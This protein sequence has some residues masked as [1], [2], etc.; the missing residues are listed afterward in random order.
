MMKIHIPK[1][2]KTIGIVPTLNSNVT[3]IYDQLSKSFDVFILQPQNK[4]CPYKILKFDFYVFM[5]PTC[6]FHYL[7]NSVYIPPDT[8]NIHL[9]L[10]DTLPAEL[11]IFNPKLFTHSLYN[12]EHYNTFIK[13]QSKFLISRMSRIQKIKDKKVFG[14]YFTNKIYKEYAENLQ[15]YLTSKS[16]N[17][18]LIFLEDISYERLTCIDNIE[19]YVVLD[20]MSSFLFDC[21]EIVVVTLYEVWIAFY[22]DIWNGDYLPFNFQNIEEKVLSDVTDVVLMESRLKN[23]NIDN[24]MTA[25]SYETIGAVNEIVEGKKGIASVYENENIE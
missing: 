1:I 24:E 2:H 22:E 10:E 25:V 19:I 12:F 5:Q 23:I 18:Y 11:P 4:V 14:I 13:N 15:K 9:Y 20:C 16:I 6:N 3:T 7:T 17:S 21:T 8:T